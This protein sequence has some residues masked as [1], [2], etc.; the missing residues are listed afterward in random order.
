MSLHTFF[1][2]FQLY[3]VL[4]Y[5]L[6]TF[7]SLPDDQF[8]RSLGQKED[9]AFWDRHARSYS[10]WYYQC[11]FSIAPMCAQRT[12]LRFASHKVIQQLPT[13]YKFSDGKRNAVSLKK[14]DHFITTWAWRIA[15]RL[16][17]AT[18]TASKNIIAPTRDWEKT[19]MTLQPLTTAITITTTKRERDIFWDFL[20]LY[21][22]LRLGRAVNMI[23]PLG[24]QL[25]W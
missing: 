14:S 15:E 2:D 22:M 10:R 24:Y 13:V 20:I 16:Q 4:F 1:P 7:I 25:S 17:K 23:N 21:I 9:S 8:K 11:S 6:W 18:N 19:T 12:Q 5:K 3:L